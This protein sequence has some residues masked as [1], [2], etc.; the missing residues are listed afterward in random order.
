M[1][2]QRDEFGSDERSDAP[3]NRSSTE[4]DSIS[5]DKV[6]QGPQ[7]L[8][9]L[10]ATPCITSSAL[11]LTDRRLISQCLIGRLLTMGQHSLQT[12]HPHPPNIAIAPTNVINI[13]PFREGLSL[14]CSIHRNKQSSACL[15]RPAPWRLLRNTWSM[16]RWHPSNAKGLLQKRQRRRRRRSSCWR[17]QIDKALIIPP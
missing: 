4:L 12:Y 11:K 3:S 15:L 9:Q 8:P 7:T 16:G 5:Q 17:V 14:D 13:A 10:Y 6:L 2:S 1:Q